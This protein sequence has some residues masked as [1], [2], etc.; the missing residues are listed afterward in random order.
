MNAI[1]PG[2]DAGTLYERVAERI[3]TL[4]QSGTLQPG[5]RVPSVRKL[6]AQF[7]VS[8]ST[9]LEAYRLLEDRALIEAR[10][11]S[12]HFVRRSRTPPAPLKTTS[13]SDPAELEL[14]DLVVRFVTDAGRPDL[15]PLGAAVA[16]PAFLPTE[17]LNRILAREVRR[18]PRCSQSYDL[19]AGHEELRVQIARRMLDA[20]CA[21]SPDEVVTCCGAQEALQLCLRAVTRP[22]DTVAVESPTYY[23]LLEALES[24]HLRALEVGTDPHDGLCLDEL[25]RA[26]GRTPVAACVFTPT[27]GNPLGHSMPVEAKREL[28]ALLAE[29]DVPLIEDDV[30]GDLWFG[31]Q[32]PE[33][34]KAFDSTGQVLF[35]SSFSKTLAPGY[36]IGWTAPGRYRSA[37]QRVKFCSSVATATPTQMAIASYLKGSGFDRHLRR[38][39]RTYRDLVQRMTAAVAEYFPEGT[40]ISRPRGGHV[41]WVELPEGADGTRLHRAALGSGISIAPGS[42]FSATQRYRNFVR[43][44]CAVV[45]SPR[46][47][48]ALRTLGALVRASST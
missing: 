22:G 28:V 42:M 46:V 5:E 18:D 24:L 3:Q 10:P 39:R 21:L 33:A 38:L 11:Q 2:T 7:A 25:R 16:S 26:L 13:G 40:R 37:V 17:R 48:E 30:F 20:G 41:L 15:V 47:V 36:R 6:S 23:G 29:A 35:C 43:L 34:A 14:K 45:W 8:V 12:G 32:R 31:A 27:V 9:V 1:A 44:N 19:L 4:I